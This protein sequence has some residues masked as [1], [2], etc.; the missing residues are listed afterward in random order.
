MICAFVLPAGVLALPPADQ[1]YLNRLNYNN[2]KLVIV[3]KTRLVS[4]SRHYGS[5]DI[6]TDIFSYEAYSNIST[7]I[8]TQS[9]NRS[10][11]KEIEEWSVI[12]GGIRKLNDLEFLQLVGDQAEFNR[13]SRIDGQKASWRLGGNILIGA[14]LAGLIGGAALSAGQPLIMGSALVM[15]GGFFLSAF[16]LAPAHY[17]QP[18]YAQQKIDEYNIKLKKKLNLPIDYN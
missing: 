4:E 12:K 14:G 13:V 1:A 10:E 3:T 2:N 5:T 15:T 8:N 17:I 18:D 6:N 9:L 11:V 7:D 16:N